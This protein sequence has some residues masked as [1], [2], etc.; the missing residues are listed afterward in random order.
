MRYIAQTPRVRR[1]RAKQY[2]VELVVGVSS[3]IQPVLLGKCLLP[4]A[5]NEP[6]Y[7]IPATRHDLAI[8]ERC[9]LVMNHACAFAFFRPSDARCK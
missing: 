5:I 9:A 1:T 8:S 3:T 7:A 6:S 2:G 4:A